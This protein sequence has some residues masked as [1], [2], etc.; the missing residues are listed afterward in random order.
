[1]SWY[2]YD[3]MAPRYCRHCGAEL[4]I[5]GPRGK[6]YGGQLQNYC[7]NTCLLR[8]RRRRREGVPEDLPKVFNRAAGLAQFKVVLGEGDATA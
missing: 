7:N 4:P 1:M 2:Q 3:P 5:S 8:G 6:R